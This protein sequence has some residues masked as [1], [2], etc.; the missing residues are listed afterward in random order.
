MTDRSDR[1]D[2]AMRPLDTWMFRDGRPFNQD[3]P[4]AAQAVGVFPPFPPTIVGMVRAQLARKLGWDGANGSW[5]SD[6]LGNGVN[7]QDQG[8]PLGSLRFSQIAVF[9]P[10]TPDR[11]IPSIL[12]PVPRA[13][14]AAKKALAALSAAWEVK[15]R[16]AA[17][18]VELT[19]V[20]L[21]PRPSL[22]L[23]CDLGDQVELAVP[24]TDKRELDALNGWWITGAGLQEFLAGNCPGKDQL[25]PEAALLAR[26]PRVGIAIDGDLQSRLAERHVIDGALYM[27]SHIRLRSGVELHASVLGLPDRTRARL[28]NLGIGPAGGE[29]RTAEFVLSK[30]PP[31]WP[32]GSPL[33]ARN[34]R[35]RY[36]VYHASP[37]LIDAL[38]GPGGRLSSLPGRVASACLERATRIGGW[39]SLNHRPVAMQPA[40]PAGSIWFMEASLDECSAGALAA[41]HGTHIGRAP[42]WGFGQILIGAW[43]D[44][45]TGENR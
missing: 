23:R 28:D 18:M 30:N 36:I 12:F 44:E 33:A 38:P 37:C 5:P 16:D 39:D 4:G 10:S 22:G 34:G 27:A 32:A 26:E 2:L 11:D 19:P 8:T 29:G 17:A 6:T 20:R 21:L 45:T 42:E 1:L 14:L 15:Q 43:P 40:I 13:L 41:H 7:W 24:Q 25:V 31:P 3:D 35:L 9:G